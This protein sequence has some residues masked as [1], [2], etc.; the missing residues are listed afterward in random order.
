MTRKFITTA[1]AFLAMSLPGSAEVVEVQMLNRG[2]DGAAMIFDP[3]Y[4]RLEPGDTIQ[5]VATDRGHNAETIDGMVPDGAEGFTGALNEEI[6]VTFE[7][8]GWYGIQCRPHFAMG[9]VMVV[10]V[11]DA[12]IPADFLEG[13]I[14]PRA[15]GRFEDAI[16]LAQ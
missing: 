12:E 14:P 3:A 13:R 9:M 5:F 6:A 8:E 16:S 1:A 11:G 10:E 4:V 2:D 15:M 7:T